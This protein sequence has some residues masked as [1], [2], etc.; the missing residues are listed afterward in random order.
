MFNRKDSIQNLDAYVQERLSDYL[1]GTL[2]AQDRAIVENYLAT[3]ENARA[4]LESLRY[5]VDL[6]KQT[7][8]PSLPRQFTLPVTARAPVS[9]TPSWMAWSLR[10]VAVAATAAFVILLTVT[11]LRQPNAIETANSPASMQAQPTAVVALAPTNEIAPM[12]AAGANDNAA[13][14]TLW[15]VTVEPNST[16]AP[17]PI[18]VQA[19]DAVQPEATQ[20]I[21]TESNAGAPPPAAQQ[22]PTVQAPASSQPTAA[23]SAPTPVVS[24]I[25][26]SASAETLPVIVTMTVDASTQRKVVTPTVNG[27]VTAEQLHIR[28]GPGFQYDSIDKLVRGGKIKVLGRD[29]TNTWLAIEYPQD[30]PTGFA[31]VAAAFVELQAPLENL[32][33]IQFQEFQEPTPTATGET[34]TPPLTPDVTSTPEAIE[35]STPSPDLSSPTPEGTTEPTP[36]G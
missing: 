27:I 7:P 10:G 17:L 30:A 29:V 26:S 9:R 32:P 35:S 6:L 25:T 11:L 18:T 5:T 24:V 13:T 16:Q 3:N 14:P 34:P 31:W 1:D 33:I 12:N 20:S 19:A 8:A 15:M 2:S 21:L 28:S 36:S 22:A 23:P 4:S